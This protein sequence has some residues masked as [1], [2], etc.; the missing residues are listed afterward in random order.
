M[1]GRLTQAR[2]GRAKGACHFSSTYVPFAE[3]GLG[4]LQ[5]VTRTPIRHVSIRTDQ[6][7]R[8]IIDAKQG[9]RMPAGVHE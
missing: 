8:S 9:Q 5:I 7:L 1:A 6:V 4:A 3:K 2:G